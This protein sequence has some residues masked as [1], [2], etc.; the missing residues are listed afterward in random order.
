[1]AY[2][3]PLILLVGLDVFLIFFAGMNYEVLRKMPSV[4]LGEWIPPNSDFLPPFSAF[5]LYLIA[6]PILTLG[7]IV[8]AVRINK[9]IK[10]GKL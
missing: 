3:I 7:I 10:E 2:I 4:F 5:H 1:M 8:S 6:I 9:W